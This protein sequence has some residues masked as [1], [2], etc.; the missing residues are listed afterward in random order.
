MQQII[1]KY[2]YLFIRELGKKLII[3]TFDKLCG[4]DCKFI[5]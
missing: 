2:C 3:L 5:E 1:K 4:L